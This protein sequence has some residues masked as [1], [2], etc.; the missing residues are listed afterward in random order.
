MSESRVGL[1]RFN[2]TCKGCGGTFRYVATLP[3]SVGKMLTMFFN[4]SIAK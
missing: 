2:A 1:P 4:V 3:K